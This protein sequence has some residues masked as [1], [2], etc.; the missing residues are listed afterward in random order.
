MV[1]KVR[2]SAN[3][4]QLAF[5]LEPVAAQ[6]VP[7]TIVFDLLGM[8]VTTAAAHSMSATSIRTALGKTLGN[9][10]GRAGSTASVGGGSAAGTGALE[11][12]EVVWLLSKFNKLFDKPL[13]DVTKVPNSR[14][15]T[16]DAVSA[17]LHEAIEGRR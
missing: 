10:P 14:W 15:S 5:Q 12:L 4:T 13:L 9:L 7:G 6:A 2:A 3:A 11:S 17:L 8:P 1:Q 16:L